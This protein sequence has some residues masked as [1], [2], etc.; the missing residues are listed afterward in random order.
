MSELKLEKPTFTFE[1]QIEEVGPY[2]F[3]AHTNV[4]S[5]R[6]FVENFHWTHKGPEFHTVI[7]TAYTVGGLGFFEQLNEPVCVISFRTTL[8]GY[9]G[10]DVDGVWDIGKLVTAPHPAINPEDLL[11]WG[12]FHIKNQNAAILLKAW[13]DSTHG[14]T[15]KIYQL[16]GWKYNGQA[17]KVKDGVLLGEDGKPPVFKPAHTTTGTYDTRVPDKLNMPDSDIATDKVH[18]SYH[19]DEGKYLY[20]L[21]LNEAGEKKAVELGYVH[22]PYPEV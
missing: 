18:V 21:P 7:L 5:V 12:L 20:Y 1:R 4:Q 19:W 3:V 15:G 22:K 16:C 8:G 9:R 2:K 6:A 13:V 14:Q 17:R 11:A 10:R